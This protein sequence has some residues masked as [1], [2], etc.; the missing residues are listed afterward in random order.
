MPANISRF[1]VAGDGPRDRRAEASQ[2]AAIRRL[3]RVKIPD[4]YELKIE[5]EKAQNSS[6][7]RRPEPPTTHDAISD[8]QLLLERRRGVNQAQVLPS[9]HRL[10]DARKAAELLSC[11]PRTVKRMAEGGEIPAM[12]IGNR[13]RFSLRMLEKWCE[14]RLSSGQRNSC[15]SER[16]E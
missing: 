1:P 9:I 3:K 8:D 2:Q 10:V 14:E 16:S 7:R 13:W 11:S 4:P 5:R 6:D 15:P 12:R